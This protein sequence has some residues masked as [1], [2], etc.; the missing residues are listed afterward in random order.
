MEIS[1]DPL[2]TYCTNYSINRVFDIMSKYN[3]KKSPREAFLL[4][5]GDSFC[6]G[7]SYRKRHTGVFIPVFF[8]SGPGNNNYV[9]SSEV[10]SIVPH[11]NGIILLKCIEAYPVSDRILLSSL[12]IYILTYILTSPMIAAR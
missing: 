12:K 10:E 11:N 3:E 8:L 1:R 7:A 5:P 2:K 6:A 9:F 4:I